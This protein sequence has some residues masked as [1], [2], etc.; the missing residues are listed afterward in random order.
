MS[1]D[2]VAAID[3]GSNSFHMVVARIS[4]GHVQILDRLR[5]MVQL[6][7]GLDDHNRLS[8]QAQ[9]RALDC[10]ARF[11]QRL[12]HIPAARLRIVGTNTLR[13]AR[14][15]AEFVAR[16][17]Q[18]LGHRVEVV[19][20]QEEARL[21]YLGV[22]HSVGD[23]AGQR[24]VI[25]IGGGSTELIIG[26]AFDPLHLASLRMGC[27]SLS[28]ACFG[29]GRV[30]ANRLREAELL[31]QLHLEPIREEYLARGWEMVTGA[32][33]SIKAIQE[34]IVR[35]G[36]SRE[37]ITLD[38]LR[39]LRGALLET[40][41]MAALSSRWQLEPPRARVFAGGFVVLHGLCEAL[42]I[43][44]LEVSEGALREGLIYDLLGRIR[45]EDVRDRTIADVI[46]R[47][48]L[49]QAQAERVCA[50]ALDLLRQVRAKWGLAG[51]E[52][53]CVLERAARLHEIGL[54]LSH[55]Q[56]HKHGA[57]VLEH[58]DLPGYSRDD[59]L[60]LAVLVRRHRRSFPADAFAALP[61]A[62]V[63]AARR[64]CALLRLAVV[65]HRG[66]SSEP[67]PPIALQVDRQ[68]LHLL[69]PSGWL[70]AHPLTRAD[71]QIEAA[72]L[73]KAGFALRFGD[74]RQRDRR[75]P[76]STS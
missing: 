34:V 18:A 12:R 68:R 32:S 4:D 15:S 50:T 37:G 29:D 55:D 13:Q 54:L 8:A 16:A 1:S 47:F 66:R 59:Q 27:V 39:R 22:A 26:E 33:G 72:L 40:S 51:K 36:W 60:L 2:F 76:P 25:D 24:L 28:R 5:E 30:T 74:A 35:E 14:N 41:D 49:D 52:A 19:S 3:L 7:A 20:G 38:A 23:L 11:A 42:G 62:T 70:A 56:Y 31:V 17:E 69:F 46:R 21:I 65:L 63:G 45:H 61:K 67:L 75:L 57:Y 71:L 64:L 9:Q 48:A 6:A 53:K 58:A 10:L 43:E 73:A 44:R